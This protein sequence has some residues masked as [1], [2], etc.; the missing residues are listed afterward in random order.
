MY[1]TVWVSLASK[2]WGRELH[3]EALADEMVLACMKEGAG[4]PIFYC[5]DSQN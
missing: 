3:E 5:S 2:H 4:Q 1:F